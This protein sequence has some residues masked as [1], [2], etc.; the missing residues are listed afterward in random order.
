MFASQAVVHGREEEK[1]THVVGP[2]FYYLQYEVKV[3]T[4]NDHGGGPNSSVVVVY[5]AEGSKL[6]EAAKIFHYTEICHYFNFLDMRS[7]WSF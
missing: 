7:K 2:E 6:L 3:G 4:F 5:S 1:Y